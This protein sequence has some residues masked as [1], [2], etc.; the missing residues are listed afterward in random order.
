MKD[1]ANINLLDL[2]ERQE[3]FKQTLDKLLFILQ[4]ELKLNHLSLFFNLQDTTT[5]T[6]LN[7]KLFE[8]FGLWTEKQKTEKELINEIQESKEYNKKRVE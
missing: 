8:R 4:S 6:E 3:I 1:T 7:I 5:E 2:N